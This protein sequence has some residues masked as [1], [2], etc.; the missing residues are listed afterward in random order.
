MLVE[1]SPK[2][3]ALSHNKYLDDFMPVP[4]TFNFSVT[5]AVER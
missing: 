5:V 4:M 2:I 3:L 1:P